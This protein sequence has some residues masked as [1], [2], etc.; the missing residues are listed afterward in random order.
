MSGHRYSIPEIILGAAA[1]VVLTVTP[2]RA[3]IAPY[4]Q[5]PAQ[6]SIHICWQSASTV[7]PV[8]RYGTAGLTNTITGTSDQLAV[9]V[10]WH[11]VKLTGLLPGTTY[12]Y[13]CVQ[14]TDSSVVFTFATAPAPSVTTGHIRFGILSDSQEYSAQSARVV[15]S[16]RAMA[17]RLWGND[18]SAALALV[19]HSG[20]ICSSGGVL[21]QYKDQ[22]FSSMASVSAFVPFMVSIGN[23]EGESEFFYR[24]MRYGEFGGRAGD[25][26]YSF[27]YGRVQFIAL[28]T[29]ARYQNDTQIAW[30]DSVC[31][32]AEGDDGVDWIFT[33][34]HHPALSEMWPDGNT[35]F[36]EAR[37]LPTLSKYTK[38]TLHQAGHTHAYERGATQEGT[39]H[40]L[41]FGGAGGAL[42]RWRMYA[43]QTDYP[44]TSRSHDHH[45]YGLVDIDLASGS[46]TFRA[47]S[48]GSQD[49]ASA[50]VTLPNTLIDSYTAWKKKL[51]PVKPVPAAL[52]DTVDLP[53]ALAASAYSGS[54]SH[55]SSQVQVRTAGGSFTTGVGVP[56]N[57]QRDAEDVYFDTGSP[58]FTA[59]DKN[60]GIDLTRYVLAASPE[61]VPGRYYWRVRYRDANLDWSDWSVER[62]FV[63]RDPALLSD[64]NR[65]VRFDGTSSYVEVASSLDSAVLP[66]QAMTVEVWVRPEAFP[67]NGA[68]IGAFQDNTGTQKGWLLG[69]VLDHL[70]FG[71]ASRGADDGNG[72]MTMLQDPNIAVAGQWYHVAGVYDGAQM[73]LIVNGIQVATSSVQSG[74][75]LYDTTSRV[76]IGAYRDVNEFS[77]FKG[78]IDEMRLWQTALSVDDIRAWM[79]RTMS[80]V[81]PSYESLISAWNFNG[82]ITTALNDL[83]GS[84]PGVTHGLT[85]ASSVRSTA[86]LG[87]EGGFFIT[88]S[89]GSVGTA[90][91]G[92]AFT[93]ISALSGSS[94]IG[95]YLV[96]RAAGTPVQSD[97]FPQDV[98]RRS[99][100][101]WGF[102]KH[103]TVTASAALKYADVAR[104]GP[105]AALRLLFRPAAD[106]AWADV[107][108]E[109]YH[110]VSNSRFIISGPMVSGLYAIGWNSATSVN[111]EVAADVP[112]ATALFQNYPNPFNPSADIRYQISEFGIVKLAVHDILGREVAVLVNEPKMPGAYQV[113]FDASGLASGVYFCR[114][115][116]RPSDPAAAGS[117]SVV[118][119]MSML[120]VR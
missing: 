23:H 21:A 32:S 94:N 34:G 93:P 58:F 8:V 82:Q 72:L 36:T 64:D 102:W 67:L 70:V 62:T 37:V 6:T 92:V 16:M 116:V 2:A 77:M 88:Q 18:L 31:T 96:G 111:Q 107:T 110:D 115:S 19:I 103:G 108:D 54:R 38:T 112:T 28:N 57:A 51:K 11:D 75:I 45:G 30:L 114:M 81:H 109:Q 10:V 117:G 101:S 24:Y 40:T 73:K 43:N 47:Y 105:D 89:A 48:L 22:Y 86:P 26:Y 66:A 27:R 17:T 98:Q 87:S 63:V 49:V 99:H 15:D 69:N 83:T 42:D 41:I 14:G 106:T 35:S 46:Y 100:L 97:V 59:I 13:R 12:S 25:K 84:N 20:D 65:A 95:V 90:G 78:A 33:Y 61:L 120:L 55:W 85:T 44:F 5:T 68:F 71:L 80:A 60:A 56:V 1:A 74:A 119:T 76:T 104:S 4:L 79:F 9:G 50:G 113:R 3:V 29:N 39:V 7:S 91:A 52:P 53:V 118:G